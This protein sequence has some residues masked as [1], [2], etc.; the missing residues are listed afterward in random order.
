M[1]H[2]NLLFRGY[3]Y[4]QPLHGCF[5]LPHLVLHKSSKYFFSGPL[6]SVCI[7]ILISPFFIIWVVN[8]TK[9]KKESVVLYSSFPAWESPSLSSYVTASQLVGH[10]PTTHYCRF[11]LSLK[12]MVFSRKERA[13][14]R[15]QS[16][17]LQKY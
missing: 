10:S 1:Q 12:K 6:I 7:L 5:I 4:L 13:L 11:F 14:V 16:L 8:L 17:P 15:T 9:K 3:L 2:L